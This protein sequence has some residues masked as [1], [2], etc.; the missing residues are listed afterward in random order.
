MS[1]WKTIDSAPKDGTPVLLW[2]SKPI[3]TND[4]VGYSP[5]R[6]LPTVIGWTDRTLYRDGSSEWK[7]GLCEEGSADTDGYSSAFMIEVFPS[8]WQPLPAPPSEND[9]QAGGMK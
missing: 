8:H 2:L 5:S 3:D 6:L 9:A 1:E 4:I 7:C